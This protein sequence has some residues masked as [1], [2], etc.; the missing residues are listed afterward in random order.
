M[1][2]SKESKYKVVCEVINRTTNKTHFENQII[3]LENRKR[4]FSDREILSKIIYTN[5][6]AINSVD[7]VV[8]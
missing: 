5:V 6:I 7:L 8:D 1:R 4:V 3:T 2:K